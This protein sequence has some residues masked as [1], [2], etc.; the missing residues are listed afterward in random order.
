MLIVVAVAAASIP[1]WA[2]PALAVGVTTHVNCESTDPS[3]P[4][5]TEAH[6]LKTLAQV[7][8]L[9][10][11]PGDQL[12]FK[13]G[14]TCEGMLAPTGAGSEAG[15]AW[16]ISNYPA[17]SPRAKIAGQGADN[18]VLLRNTE[19]VEIA[20]LEL[21]NTASEVNDR[22][23]LHV[24]LEDF[25]PGTHYRVSNLYVHDISG[26]AHG[27]TMSSQGILF[28]VRGSQAASSFHD[29]VVTNN[30]VTGTS[31]G[32]IQ[33]GSSFWSKRT[34]VGST[35]EE[36]AANPW[37]PHTDIVLADNTITDAG[38]SG[39]MVEI[40]AGAVVENNV[41]FGHSQIPTE[42]SVGIWT[43][44]SNDTVIQHN[45]VLG[46]HQGE[47]DGMAFD[48]DFATVRATIQYNYSASNTGGF[49][50]LCP[51][52]GRPTSDPVVRYN[53]SEND[54]KRGIA[55]CTGGTV[56]NG[57]IY[58][59]TI[60]IGEGRSM[61]V[62]NQPAGSHNVQFRNNIVAKEGSGA[63]WIKLR[64]GT[65]VQ[66]SHNILRNVL[67][68]PDSSNTIDFDP[69]L[70][71]RGNGTPGYQL[72]ETS[73][74]HGSGAAIPQ[75]GSRDFY[76]NPVASSGSVDVGA[77][78]GDGTMGSP[79]SPM[80]SGGPNLLSNG[81]FETG[82]KAPWVTN[83]WS[84]TGAGA[85]TGSYGAYLNAPNNVGQIYQTVNGLQPGGKYVL[86][87]WVASL[88]G[89]TTSCFV[90]DFGSSES[91]THAGSGW[92]HFAMTFEVSPGFSSAT[93]GC[94]RGG[95]APAS[96][97]LDDISLV[98]IG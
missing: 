3:P 11:G 91:T 92:W 14:T 88:D 93:V 96:T 75:N 68:V 47:K 54:T 7:N 81:D 42:A 40:T 59:N 44:N 86:S 89:I 51:V 60:Y 32:A 23:G 64:R 69:L 97:T 6:P 70:S 90:K 80:D 66:F 10:F 95:T 1:A 83:W 19:W 45:S 39:I 24:L 2:G 18:A 35:P 28:S 12:L 27:G 46:G 34:E 94:H 16:V 67:G 48:A 56:H 74:A 87:G 50:L 76:G 85:H 84:I 73:L 78:E 38:T 31:H 17:G 41:V 79:P 62:F 22:R 20:N 61:T 8:A 71:A 58:N 4:D 49:L 57:Q 13:G 65:S 98:Q 25:G 9:T 33:F 77:Y 21:T 55:L 30:R 5:G 72:H 26:N 43:I 63:A 52:S 36:I 37:T 15:G 82:E 29:A 53:I